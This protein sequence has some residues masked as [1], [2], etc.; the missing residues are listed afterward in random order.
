MGSLSNISLFENDR[1]HSVKYNHVT[2]INNSPKYKTLSTLDKNDVIPS[3]QIQL[4]QINYFPDKDIKSTRQFELNGNSS[5]YEVWEEEDHLI[6]ADYLI[7]SSIFPTVLNVALELDLLG[8]ISRAGLGCQLTTVEIAAQLPSKNLEA[9]ASMLDRI[10]RLL[11]SNRLLTCSVL[12]VDGRSVRRYG[13]PPVGRY[14]VPDEDGVSL[15]PLL[16]MAGHRAFR[17][18]RAKLKEAILEGGN[19][20]HMA[21]GMSAFEYAKVDTSFNEIFNTAMRNYSTVMM[22]NVVSKY[23][24][25]KDTKQLVK[26]AGGSGH[27]IHNIISKYPHIKGI[28]FDLPHVIQ[29]AIPL[30]GVEHISGD[31]FECLPQGDAI[32]MKWIIHDWEDEKCIK[33]LRNCYE[34]LPKKGKVVII[35]G[36]LSEN[37][38]S[39][40]EDKAVAQMDIAMLTQMD[41]G[42]ERTKEDFIALSQSA[43]FFDIH[44]I[45]S[46]C[47]YWIIEL[48]K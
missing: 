26:V 40:T 5:P 14:L 13:L 45:C 28:N 44:F 46:F 33:L 41:Q 23:K 11:V 29:N 2:K 24:G 30:L 27:L 1:C 17:L 38:Q 39:T 16:S 21:H 9:T 43:G 18:S 15:T 31:M 10:L 25:F 34:S 6:Y 35:E 36:M 3:I 8:I 48:Y 12:K 7:T 4:P 42:K 47:N 20:F 32:L 22:R 19:P 37:P